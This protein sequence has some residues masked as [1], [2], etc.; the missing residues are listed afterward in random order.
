MLY[1]FYV[2]LGECTVKLTSDYNFTTLATLHIRTYKMFIDLA[3]A[4]VT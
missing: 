1:S 4:V 3:L 2:S